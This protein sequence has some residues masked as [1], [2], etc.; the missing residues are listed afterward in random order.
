MYIPGVPQKGPSIAKCLEN[1]HGDVE[2]TKFQHPLKVFALVPF[3]KIFL[4]MDYL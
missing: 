2:K 3:L 4:K 1:C